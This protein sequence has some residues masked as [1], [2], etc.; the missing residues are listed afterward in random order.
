MATFEPHPTVMW[1]LTRA[2]DLRCHGCPSGAGARRG[3]NE[4][5]TYEAYKTVDQIAALKP[6]ELIITGGDPLL[7]D[8]VAQVIDY[9]RRRGLEPSLVLSPT[10]DL[11]LDAIS[12]LQRNGLTRACFSVDGSTAATHQSVHCVEGTFAATLRAMRWA[13]CAGLEIEVNTLVCRRNV[14]E[15]EAIVELIRPFEVTRWNPHFVVPVGDSREVGMLTASEVEAVFLRIDDIRDAGRVP[16]R[17][18]EAPH[19][20]RFRLERTLGS[21]LKS[22]EAWADFTSYDPGIPDTTNELPDCALDGAR[23]FVYVSHAGDVRPSEFVPQSAGNLRYRKLTD[24][25]R[26][27]DLFVALRDPANLQGKCGHCDYQHVCGGSRARAWAVTGDL[28]GSDPL[29]AYEP[30]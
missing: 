10:Q 3:S 11:T 30:C 27:S 2:C 9:A 15:L 1:E 13:R 26:S 28:F 4:L 19:F 5:T 24:I 6:R 18:V 16:V 17:V 23:A 8:D 25:C 22:T 29:C 7:R 14:A 20:R 21:M 12:E